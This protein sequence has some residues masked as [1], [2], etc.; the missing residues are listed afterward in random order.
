MGQMIITGQL[1]PLRLGRPTTSDKYDVAGFLVDATEVNGIKAGSFLAYG[2]NH[3]NYTGIKS[4]TTAEKVAGV[5][6]D[7]LGK[8]TRK[9][10]MGAGE[11]DLALPGEAGDVLIRGDIAVELAPSISTMPKEGDKVYLGVGADVL[12]Y[13]TTSAGATT[14]LAIELPNFRFLGINATVAGK[15]L[16]AVR[17]LY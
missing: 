17:K 3:K 14:T 8:Q 13:V 4:T 2:T 5:F 11:V 6:V 15:K 7:S 16:V 10:P 1:Q 9:Y 12:G